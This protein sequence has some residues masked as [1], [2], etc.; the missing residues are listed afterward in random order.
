MT[1]YVQSANHPPREQLRELLRFGDDIQERIAQYKRDNDWRILSVLL[2]PALNK[3][4]IAHHK[5]RIRLHCAMTALAAERYRLQ[6]NRWP[7]AL[8]DLVPDFL[9]EVPEDVF[10]DDPLRIK[11]LDDGLV[12]Y[13]LG[14]DFTD[15][16]GL[17]LRKQTPG[18]KEPQDVGFRLYNPD[19][20][21]QA[22]PPTGE[23][24]RD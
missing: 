23:Q 4:A 19:K 1:A 21:R 14:D 9:Q 5:A 6:H 10:S 7:D 22:A 17:L 8:T 3:I 24:P 20:R 15:D 13:S 12:I 16:G 2:I 18:V 11:K